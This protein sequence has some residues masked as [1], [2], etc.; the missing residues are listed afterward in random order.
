M[1]SRGPVFVVGAVASERERL[2]QRIAEA[3]QVDV[4]EYEGGTAALGGGVWVVDARVGAERAARLRM[5]SEGVVVGVGQGHGLG[6]EAHWMVDPAE[7]EMDAWVSRV[8]EM[9]EASPIVVPLG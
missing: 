4:K 2:A 1:G 8:V 7:G 9:S 3:A 5:L 6:G